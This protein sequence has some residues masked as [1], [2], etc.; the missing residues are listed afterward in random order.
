MVKKLSLSG[1][2]AIGIFDSGYGGLTVLSGIKQVMPEYDYIYLGDNARAPY[3]SRSFESV[4]EFTLEAVEWFFTQGCHLVILACN[5]A[6]AKALRTIQQVNLPAIDPHKRVLGVIRPTV[7]CLT[8]LSQTNHIGVLGTEGTIQSQSYE[9]EINKLHPAL[10][11]T[12]EACPM[13]VPLVEN[14]E[15][16]KPG[17]DYFVKQHIDRLLTKDP[18][19]DTL[20][21]GCTHY[22]LLLPVIN[23]FLPAHMK[24]ISQGSYVANSLKDYLHRHPEMAERCTK[25]GTVR[26]FTTES[27]K[28]FKQQAS[29]FLNEAVDAERTTL[30]RK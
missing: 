12:G 26:Y 22:P 18:L 25:N 23:R 17:A 11:V 29:L 2:G 21:L 19:I 13:W 28:K 15:F 30:T 27:P 10:T 3:G 16:D 9:I 6:S 8:G 14:R 1:A 20:L 4:Y 5:T 7:E 24:V